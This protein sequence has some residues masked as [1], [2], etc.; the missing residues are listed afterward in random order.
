MDSSNS[1][2]RA[3]QVA[4]VLHGMRPADAGETGCAV[5]N[6][7]LCDV[8]THHDIFCAACADEQDREYQQEMD[9]ARREWEQAEHD[10]KPPSEWHVWRNGEWRDDESPF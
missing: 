1:E 10:R 6:T 7:L 9:Y 4:H 8:C 2:E 3:A 5:C